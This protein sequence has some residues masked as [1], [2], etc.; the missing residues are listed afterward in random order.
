MKKKQLIS[1]AALSSIAAMGFLYSRKEKEEFRK[2]FVLITGASSGIGLELTR[3]FAQDGYP[4]IL[5]ARNKEKLDQVKEELADIQPNIITITC[6]LS[7]EENVFDLYRSIQEMNLQVGTLVNN[8][9]AGKS[10]NLMEVDEQTCLDLIHLNV[11]SMTLLTQLFAK[12][13]VKRNQGSILF[14]ASTAAFGPD[15][16]L[17]V[18]GPSKAFM[19]SFAQTLRAELTNTKVNVTC[20][21]PGPTRTNWS[22]N[23][24]RKDSRY[25]MDVKEVARCAYIGLQHHQAL[26]IPGNK[27]KILYGMSKVVPDSVI[28]K[29]TATFQ[30]N[31]K[32]ES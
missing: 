13:M 19:Y 27:N 10:G 12:E 15:A 29:V 8:A 3:M 32:K 16:G 18:Y 1:I 21:C 17:N 2:E 20:V 6:D 9:G 30:K 7:K 14:V 25:A 31:L 23:A 26:V 28:G 24:G 22:E 5:V 11:S 4:L